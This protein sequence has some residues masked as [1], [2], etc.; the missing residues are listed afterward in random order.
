[1][2]AHLRRILWMARRTGNF[3]SG[4]VR[5]FCLY[6]GELMRP[7]RHLRIPRLALSWLLPVGVAAA[8]AMPTSSA[9]A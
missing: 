7:C 8:M 2:E 4:A 3:A 9:L 5:A 1:M 6:A